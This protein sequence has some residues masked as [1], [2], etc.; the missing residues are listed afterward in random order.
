MPSDLA[1]YLASRYLVADPKPSSKKRKRKREAEAAGLLIQDDDDSWGN[2]NAQ[3]DDAEDGPVTVSSRSAEFRKAKG[4]NWKAVGGKADSANKDEDAAAEAILASA[5]AEN[6]AS[7]DADEGMPVVEE[8]GS[9][10]KMSDG[11]H[12]GL[13]S[14]SAVSAQL[15]RR[16]REERE[17][18]E[19]HR[20]SAKEEETVYRDATGRRIDISM[21]RAEAR[22]AAAEA[23][24]KERLAKEALKGEVQLEEA[25]KRRE[26]LEDAKLMNFAR[27]ADDEEMNAELKEQ[28][29]WNDPMMQFMSEKK[30]TRGEGKKSKRKPVYTGAAPP[31]RYGI[32]PGYRWDGVDRG[33]GFEGERFKAINR[34]ERNKGLDYSWQMDE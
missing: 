7:R 24:E 9:V 19:R 29:R 31:N 34:R 14:A 22:K 15:K 28:E 20:K 21:K 8:N 18:F 16:Q 2:S 12:A 6:D 23:E 17:D 13:Q 26:K 33:N 25:R 27:T 11:T 1:D 5:A 3:Q 4:S 10:V 32:K 30:G